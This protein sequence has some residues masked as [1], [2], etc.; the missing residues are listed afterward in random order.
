MKLCPKCQT[1]NPGNANYCRHCKNILNPNL[2]I[3]NFGVLLLKMQYIAAYSI[4]PIIVK[5][6]KVGNIYKNRIVETEYGQTLYSHRAMYLSPQIEYLGLCEC[7]ITLYLKLYKEGEL[8]I[9]ST[10]PAGYTYSESILCT[11]NYE[12]QALGGW[13]YE[14]A[15]SWLQGNY[16][17]EVWYENVCLKALDFKIYYQPVSKRI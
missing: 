5:S 8:Q 13:G 9:K 16:R 17:Y 2:N 14:K 4:S 1:E 15:G 11:A 7:T 6:L 3:N 10:L 12:K